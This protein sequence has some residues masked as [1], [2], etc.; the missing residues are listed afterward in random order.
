MSLSGV[1]VIMGRIETA[2]KTSQ[3]AVFRSPGSPK[4]TLDA[5][6]ANT[7]RTKNRVVNDDSLLIGVFDKRMDRSEV[8]TKLNNAVGRF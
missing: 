5:V 4:G 7:V 2:E 3:I 1:S 8:R 6:F